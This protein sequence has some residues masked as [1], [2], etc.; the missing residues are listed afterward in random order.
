MAVRLELRDDTATL[1]DER[2]D[3]A[4]T[5]SKPWP[6][7]ATA[8]LGARLA[9]L[10]SRDREEHGHHDH[11]AGCPKRRHPAKG[12]V[13]LPSL[14][15]PTLTKAELSELLFDHLGL[16]KRESKDMVEAFFDI[17]HDALVTRRRRQ[18]VGLRQLQHPA[19]GPAARAQPAHRRS[20]P[21]QGAQRGH[22]S[23]KSQIEEPR[24]RRHSP[25]ATTSS[26]FSA[27]VLKPVDFN[28]ESAPS[29]SSQDAT[30]PSVR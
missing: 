7:R 23:R 10:T 19:Q 13:I 27:F 30:S 18:A 1:T 3:N 21:D 15:T 8:R 29:H 6:G 5:G 12:G 16:N 24:A 2:I 17:L 25:P 20:D 14:E 26:R 22:I 11:A 28:G 9:R 4:A